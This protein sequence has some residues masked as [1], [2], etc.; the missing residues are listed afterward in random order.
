MKRAVRYIAKI[1][2]TAVV[3]T[4]GTLFADVETASSYLYW[5]F[6]DPIIYDIDGSTY[7][8]DTLAGRGDAGGLT[9]NAV[10]ISMT[11][12]SG[13]VSYLTSMDWYGNDFG[14]FQ[15]IPDLN[16]ENL[17]G[18][19][20]INLSQVS[21]SLSDIGLSFAMEIGYAE[22]GDDFTL[23]SWKIMAST[24]ESY[25]A[26]RQGGFVGNT[27]IDIQSHIAWTPSSMV[28]PEPNSGILLLTG[29]CMLLLCRKRGL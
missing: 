15:T 2:A 20:Q 11:D 18:P 16:G 28:V 9:P 25:E 14:N 4:A 23:N 10:R 29:I 5:L 22:W 8:A 26:L 24:S 19:M 3:M 7:H 6:D 17:A 1:I 12:S 13:N 21:G 27:P